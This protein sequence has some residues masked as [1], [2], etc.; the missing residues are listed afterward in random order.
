MLLIMPLTVIRSSYS[1]EP[2]TVQNLDWLAKHWRVSKSEALRR[3]IDERALSESQA[4]QGKVT[5]LAALQELQNNSVSLETAQAWL[6]EV[7]Q[8]RNDYSQR[9]EKQWNSFTSTPTT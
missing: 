9:T 5:P 8:S 7:N 2:K 3:I 6:A 4:L 1:F